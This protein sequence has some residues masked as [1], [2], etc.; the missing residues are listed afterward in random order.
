[1]SSKGDF[2][3]IFPYS[4]SYRTS[5]ILVYS[6]TVTM[7]RTSMIETVILVTINHMFNSNG[8]LE[9]LTFPYQRYNRAY[10]LDYNCIEFIRI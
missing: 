2:I 3:N 10:C 6:Q 9:W 7:V 1:M 8:F 5:L 4:T